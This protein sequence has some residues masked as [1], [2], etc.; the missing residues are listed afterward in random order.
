MVTSIISPWGCWAG[1]GSFPPSLCFVPSPFFLFGKKRASS[2]GHPAISCVWASLPPR[3]LTTWL[4]VCVW[5]CS[6]ILQALLCFKTA[7][8]EP[9]G[10]HWAQ[11]KG[12]VSLSR[13]PWSSSSPMPPHV[14][15]PLYCFLSLPLLS[16]SLSLA[17]TRRVLLL[18]PAKNTSARILSVNPSQGEKE[19]PS[20]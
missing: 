5:L 16:L 20:D 11:S 4:R 12:L 9:M 15:R 18:A 17:H 10:S 14:A 13:L 6:S 7:A 2:C 1:S 8:R 19:K 3:V